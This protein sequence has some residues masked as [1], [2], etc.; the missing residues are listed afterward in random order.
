M[1]ASPIKKAEGFLNRAPSIK[2]AFVSPGDL[3]FS[4]NMLLASWSGDTVVFAYQRLDDQGKASSVTTA[5]HM[6][7]LEAAIDA[8]RVPCLM[9]HLGPRCAICRDKIKKLDSK[10]RAL[11]GD[12]RKK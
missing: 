2:G 4:Y 5:R 8:A 6:R 1:P 9:P 10:G 3:G 11:C 7:A 12:C